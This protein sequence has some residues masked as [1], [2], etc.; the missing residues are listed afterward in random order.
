MEMVE[1]LALRIA[2]ALKRVESEKTASIEVM[3]FALEAIL[4]TLITLALI[5]IVGIV[6]G[7]LGS[8]MLG[9]AAF[10]FLRF[11][12]GGLH[13]NSAV[14][15]SLLSAILISAAPHFHLVNNW[16]IMVGSVSLALILLL[17]PA[18]IEGH[19][20]IPQKY[21]FILKLISAAIVC[22]NFFFLNSTLSIVFAIQAVTLL[23]FIKEVRL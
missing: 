1:T 7:S 14:H 20:R 10:A 12:A 11:F 8:T 3:K 13:L 2:E 4:N 23:P 21:F 19:A 22:S 5:V 16:I 9:F 6:T 15:C 17:A 18:N